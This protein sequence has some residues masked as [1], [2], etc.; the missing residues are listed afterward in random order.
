ML[1]IMT[2]GNGVVA[3]QQT[4]CVENALAKCHA[5]ASP[6]FPTRM[7]SAVIVNL[8]NDDLVSKLKYLLNKQG[9]EVTEEYSGA[10]KILV[11]NK[12]GLA[13]DD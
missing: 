12:Y 3:K 13:K 5:G 4:R 10:G 1:V 11:F 6:V 8:E 2:V 7:N 9:Y